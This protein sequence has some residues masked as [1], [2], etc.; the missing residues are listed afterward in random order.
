MTE[1]KE[2]K[3][4]PLRKYLLSSLRVFL[5]FCFV[6]FFIAIMVFFALYARIL[7]KPIDLQFLRPLFEHIISDDIFDIKIKNASIIHNYDVGLLGVHIDKVA[8]HNKQTEK[9][10]VLND[11]TLDIS[12]TSLF[13]Q[14]LGINSVKIHSVKIPIL[15]ISQLESQSEASQKFDL[16]KSLNNIFDTPALKP[17]KRLKVSVIHAS[18]QDINQSVLKPVDI[19]I[20]SLKFKRYY[21]LL[22]HKPIYDLQ[23]KFTVDNLLLNTDEKKYIKGYIRTNYNTQHQTASINLKNINSSYGQISFANANMNFN[24]GYFGINAVTDNIHDKDFYHETIG[25]K[26]LT[27]QGNF[28]KNNNDLSLQNY[29]LLFDDFVTITGTAALFDVKPDFTDFSYTMNTNISHLTLPHL[30]K[31]WSPKLAI[32]AREWVVYNLKQATFD[33]AVF[34]IT[35]KSHQDYPEKISLNAPITDGTFTYLSPMIPATKVNGRLIIDNKKFIA[36]VDTGMIDVINVKNTSFTIHDILSPKPTGHIIGHLE[37]ALKP[38]LTIIDSK[39]LNLMQKG[40]FGHKNTVGSFNATLKMQIPL[41]IGVKLS[42]ITLKT[43]V[44]VKDA[45]LD[46]GR[47]QLPIQNIQAKLHLTPQTADGTGTASLY[48]INSRFK[49]HENFDTKQS[50]TTE[51]HLTT[52]TINERQAEKLVTHL[53]GSAVN[54]PFYAKGNASLKSDVILRNGT[55]KK[56]VING[57]VS[58]MYCGYGDTMWHLPPQTPKDLTI[59]ASQQGDEF[60][61]QKFSIKNKKNIFQLSDGV[62]DKTGILKAK[63]DAINFKNIIRGMSG[64]YYKKDNRYYTDL[65][66]SKLFLQPIIDDAYLN[67]KKATEIF[68]YPN[69]MMRLKVKKLQKDDLLII[70][71]ADIVASRHGDNPHLMYLDIEAPSFDTTKVH[72]TETGIETRKITVQSHNAGK[73]LK[74]F[75]ILDNFKKG[76]LTMRMTQK[77]GVITGKALI[78]KG[79]IYKSPLM[80]KLLS[81]ASL[82]GIEDRLNNRGLAIDKTMVDFRKSDNTISF[83]NGTIQGSAIGMSFQG[84]HDVL[85]QTI[86]LYGTLVPFYGLNSALSNI[87]IVGNI[88][89]SRNTEGV[90]GMGYTIKGKTEKP[91][92]TV[93]PLSIF[94]IGILRRI[95]EDD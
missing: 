54:I 5:Q 23:Y 91:E 16:E 73:L 72:I 33:T 26:S 90:V 7:W 71:N 59:I 14:T 51:I 40:G 15:N 28:N 84:K 38:L 52:P 68:T 37:G 81:L 29:E 56:L 63:I 22:N 89:S 47:K 83:K 35:G 32:G 21:G 45:S 25:L 79:K 82:S 4:I 75:G 9:N 85:L 49:W 27:L 69:L 8:I 76:H 66:A 20:S 13:K 86:N 64:H 60:L 11:I 70:D 24:N 77:S 2:K 17:F 87:P 12:K 58:N 30:L 53:S 57:D 55:I 46:I 10:Y 43:D 41:L 80:A 65:D 78:K 94:T 92:I 19:K 50:I 62:I 74:T 48:G 93:N 1:K 36:Q 44:T 34:N 6:A 88:V 67:K 95:F 18:L 42:D 31:L 39:P 3:P 61:V